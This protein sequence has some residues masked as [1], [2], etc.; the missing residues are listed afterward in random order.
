MDNDAAALSFVVPSYNEEANLEGT[1]AA[2]AAASADAGV[3]YEI[4]VLDDGSS[5]GTFALA[6][7]LAAAEPRIRALTNGRNRGLGYTFGRGVEESQGEHVMLVPGDNEVPREAIAALL[8]GATDSDLTL[9]YF[10]D[11]SGRPWLRRLLSATYT[12]LVN[13]AVG[14]RIHYYNGPSVM[15]RELALLGVGRAS[16]FAYM[17]LHIL[18]ALD[19]GAG[20]REVAVP[21]APRSAGRSTALRARNWWGVARDLGPFLLTRSLRRVTRRR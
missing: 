1:V 19:A 12:A 14:R 21:L 5:D 3:T 16:S 15:R 2:I 20:Y 11:Q 7:R 8:R 17:T 4:V 13:F 6:Q 9:G 18:L 10:P